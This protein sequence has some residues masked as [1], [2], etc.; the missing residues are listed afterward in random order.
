MS[1][2]FS[3]N[4]RLKIDLPCLSKEWSMYPSHLKEAILLE[5]ERIRGAI[6]DRIGEIDE[7]IE[8]L[9]SRLGEEEDFEESCRLNSEISEKASQINDLWIWYRTSPYM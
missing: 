3:Y 5:W 8:E 4:R 9:Q 7:E 1:S 2:H 6:P